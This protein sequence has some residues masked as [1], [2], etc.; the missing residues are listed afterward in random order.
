M[1]HTGILLDR[2]CAPFLFAI[3]GSPISDADVER[4]IVEMQSIHERDEPFVMLNLGR[5]VA[6]MTSSQR[7]RLG[8]WMKANVEQSRRLCLGSSMLIASKPARGVITALYW[9]QPPPYPYSIVDTAGTAAKAILQH[10]T[11]AKLAVPAVYTESWL[12]KKLEMIEN[13]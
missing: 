7:A 10:A 8:T 4:F 11:Q 9:L 3:F 12:T 13:A 5:G 2:S 6:I 1:G